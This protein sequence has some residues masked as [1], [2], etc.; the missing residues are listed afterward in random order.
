MLQRLFIITLLGLGAVVLTARAQECKDSPL[1]TPLTGCHIADCTSSD[2]NAAELTISTTADTRTK[3]VE[4]KYEYI[5]YSCTGKSALQ[6]RRNSEQAL[7]SAGFTLDFTGYDVPTHY[8][9]AHKGPQW[10]AVEA[11]EMTGDSDYK[12]MTVLTE[13]MKQ[14]MTSNA[15]AFAAEINKTGHVAVY[16]I[17]F[18][19]GKATLRAESEPVLSEVLKLLKNNP[20]WKMRVEGNT[21]S[22]GTKAGNMTLSQQR[23]ASVVAWLTK[24]GVA[25]ARLTAVG[26]G[27]SKPL[28]DNGSADG[29]ARNRRV[30][31][32][33]Q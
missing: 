1:L 4:G 25:A 18:D 29:R 5:H 14:E 22:T 7:R 2:F 30:E 10:V 33:K 23:A 16:G 20:G 9:T 12:L 3:H 24:N 27:D 11:S 31:L 13:E 15:E 6:V 19:T 21:D 26:M 17:E 28:A 32:V 8:V